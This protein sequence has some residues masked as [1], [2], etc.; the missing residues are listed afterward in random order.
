MVLFVFT[1]VFTGALRGTNEALEEPKRSGEGDDLDC[2]GV[3]EGVSIK[4]N[5]QL[6]GSSGEDGRATTLAQD[7]LK[8]FILVEILQLIQEEF[9]CGEGIETRC[10]QC[11]LTR[12]QETTRKLFS[13]GPESY[14]VI[15]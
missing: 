5:S 4:L 6:N 11:K 15:Q 7:I 12:H 13:V 1:G 3:E 10:S 9:W 2:V 14:F 8:R